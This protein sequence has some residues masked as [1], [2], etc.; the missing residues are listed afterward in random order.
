MKLAG[1]VYINSRGGTKRHTS[2]QDPSLCAGLFAAFCHY[3]CVSAAGSAAPCQRDSL[4]GRKA[5]LG[6]NPSV[7]WLRV[8]P[9]LQPWGRRAVFVVQLPLAP[10][11]FGVVLTPGCVDGDRTAV[12]KRLPFI[13]C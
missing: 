9:S 6:E 4:G 13:P 2:E 12:R 3:Q 11:F 1:E 5:H 7:L 10:I 8:R